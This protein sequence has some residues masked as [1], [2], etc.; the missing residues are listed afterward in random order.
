MKIKGFNIQ[1]DREYCECCTYFNDKVRE[2]RGTDKEYNKPCPYKR[3][4]A[5]LEKEEWEFEQW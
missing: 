2:H 3:T 4:C 1:M 5:A